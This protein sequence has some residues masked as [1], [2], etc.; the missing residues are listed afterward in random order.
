MRTFNHY[1]PHASTSY[2]WDVSTVVAAILRQ[3]HQ[4]MDEDQDW[5]ETVGQSIQ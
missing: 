3:S 2:K 4:V 5:I 1:T